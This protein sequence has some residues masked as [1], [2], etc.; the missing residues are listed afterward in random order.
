LI[1]A[2][3]IRPMVDLIHHRRLCKPRRFGDH[4]PGD[5]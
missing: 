1:T 3:Y 4:R 2:T 5:R